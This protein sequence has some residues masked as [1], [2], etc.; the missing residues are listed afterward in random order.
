M[1][2]IAC[3]GSTLG[4]YRVCW[5]IGCISQQDLYCSYNVLKQEQTH[6]SDYL[7]YIFVFTENR[8]NIQQI[9][10][11]HG[12]IAT[13]PWHPSLF[14]KQFFITM[15]ENSVI[16]ASVILDSLFAQCHYPV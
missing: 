16:S 14:I 4:L 8:D 5:V 10:I 9:R 13:M 7:G 15:F 3:L 6:Q 12:N 2:G 1:P 11:A